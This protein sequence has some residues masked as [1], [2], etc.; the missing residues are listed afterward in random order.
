MD[1]KKELEKN[2]DRFVSDLAGLVAIPSIATDPE[3]GFPFGKEVQ[4]AFEY[5]LD[6][7]KSMG[8]KIK[9]VDNYGGH[10]D[11]PGTEDGVMAIVGHIDVVPI[12]SGWTDDPFSGKVVDGWLYGRGAQDDKGPTMAGLYAMKVLK[13]LGFQPKKTIRLILGL[14][15]EDS[16]NGMKYYL[17][18]EKAPDFGIVPDAEFPLVQCEKGLF[19]FDLVHQAYPLS[20]GAPDDLRLVAL[21]GGDA[22]NMVAG[23]VEARISGNETALKEMQQLFKQKAADSDYDAKAV[24]S[25][26]QEL[27]LKVTGIPAHAAIPQRGKN[28]IS[29]ACELLSGIPFSN[30]G[31]TN[32]VDF[33]QNKIG[34]ALD[35]SKLG[36]HMADQLFGG[37]TFN[38]GKVLFDQNGVRLTCDIRYPVTKSQE[39]VTSAIE[40][41]LEGTG[42]SLEVLDHIH[43]IYQESD[44]PVVVAL[45]DTYREIT[46]DTVTQPTVMGGATFARAIPNCMAY[47][48]LFP[49]DPELEHQADERVEIAQ[50][51]K[52][53]H[54][55][56]EAIYKLTK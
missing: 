33:Y 5:M 8:F 15:E 51:L 17:E 4:H 12:G 34:F 11:W 7:G 14:D 1:I 31:A 18:K 28:A 52:A 13:D 10:I 43:S 20:S 21:A 39:I 38:V 54:I 40:K 56:G 55:Y 53:A 19:E 29:M 36:C 42:Y 44:N 41:G 37:L 46:G 26:P 9:N 24:L 32:F 23:F 25:S 35:G 49:G 48:A 3:G 6:L 45:I 2:S 16:W 22:P 50:L 30:E 47:G 27:V